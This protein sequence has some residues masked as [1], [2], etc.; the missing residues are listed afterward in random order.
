MHLL[1]ASA[2]ALLLVAPLPPLAAQLVQGQVVAQ[3]GKRPLLGVRVVL[4][5][6]GSTVVREAR[7]DSSAG[8]FFIDVPRPGR[9][10]LASF[11]RLGNSYASSPF[12]VDSGATIERQL[13]LPDLPASFDGVPVASRHPHVRGMPVPRYPDSQRSANHTGSVRVAFIVAADG[14]IEPESIRVIASTH[15][16]FTAA[17]ARSLERLSFEPSSAAAPRPPR[18]IVQLTFAFG[19]P[20]APFPPGDIEVTVTGIQHVLP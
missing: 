14:T 4:L 9:Y 1:T 12:A 10:R 11:D 7:S 15:E 8:Y 20:G 13:M 18:I 19:L 16:D 6:E 3:D 2:L 17:V 5:D